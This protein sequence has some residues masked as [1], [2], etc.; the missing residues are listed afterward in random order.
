VREL[1]LIT[2]S[3]HDRPA[4]TSSISSILARH[5]ANILDIGQ[6]VIHDHLSLGI[7]VEFFE[8]PESSKAVKEILYKMHALDMRVKFQP[9]D[10]NDY[11]NWVNQQGKE[12]HIITLL[13]R[14]ISAEHIAALT[15]VVAEHGLCLF[16]NLWCAWAR[17]P[18]QPMLG[19]VWSLHR[20]L[21]TTVRTL[22][23]PAQQT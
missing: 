20:I 6:A 9:I 15:S 17:L 12:R 21:C 19:A 8:E 3:G 18:V 7:L 23:V 14:Q 16:R 1:I 2:L 10:E 13:A 5:G 11:E 22:G 4:V